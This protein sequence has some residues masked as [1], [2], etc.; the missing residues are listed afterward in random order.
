MSDSLSDPSL[1]GDGLKNEEL[2]QQAASDASSGLTPDQIAAI[3]FNESRAL[4]GGDALDQARTA[5]AATIMNA[6]RTWGANRSK[7]AGTAPD[8]LPPNISTAEQAD[9]RDI[10]ESVRRAQELQAQGQDP[11]GG[12]TNYN[13]RLTRSEAPPAG[14][15]RNFSSQAIHGPFRRLSPLQSVPEHLAQSGRGPIQPKPGGAMKALR[16]GLAIALFMFTAATAIAAED[17]DEDMGPSAFLRNMRSWASESDGIVYASCKISP[18]DSQQPDWLEAY[19]VLPRAQKD[20][21]VEF[22]VGTGKERLLTDGVSFVMHKGALKYTDMLQGGDWMLDFMLRTAKALL[23]GNL[24]LSYSLADIIAQHP[25]N[26]CKLPPSTY[27][28]GPR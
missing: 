14:S 21:Q 8:V 22:F 23:A 16:R 4:R 10:L 9:L 19:L 13:F 18:Q 24:R 5:M 15:R 20:G 11:A 27:D 6:Q 2:A 17:E 12:A 26:T 1:A 25:R 3:I 7:H 28:S